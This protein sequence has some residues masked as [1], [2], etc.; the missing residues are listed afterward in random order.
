MRFP[1]ATEPKQ[2]MRNAAAA[3]L[4]RRLFIGD[5]NPRPE[6]QPEPGGLDGLPAALD[7]RVRLVGEW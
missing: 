4:I 3:E 5:S 2:P 6:P 7:E 1:A